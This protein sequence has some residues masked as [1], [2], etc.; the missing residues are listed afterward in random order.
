MPAST[1]SLTRRL[2]AALH[3]QAA[4]QGSDAVRSTLALFEDARRESDNTARYDKF[5]DVLA[6]GEHLCLA[7]KNRVRC[8]CSVVCKA[9]LSAAS[10]STKCA[11]LHSY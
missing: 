5:F 6:A 11:L 4:G 3:V 2:P 7:L 8:V 9:R 10:A 1:T